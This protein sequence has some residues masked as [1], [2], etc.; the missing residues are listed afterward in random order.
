MRNIIIL[1]KSETIWLPTSGFSEN[2]MW[3]LIFL[4]SEVFYQ[5]ALI[6]VESLALLTFL[7][8]RRFVLGGINAPSALSF[9]SLW[10]LT[11]NSSKW[12]FFLPYSGRWKKVISEIF[13]KLARYHCKFDVKF[14]NFTLL[15]LL[16]T[17][18]LWYPFRPPSLQNLLCP[19]HW[20]CLF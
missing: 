16:Q 15:W 17:I 10:F 11:F 2:L 20:Y 9:A 18:W 14:K 6:P 19:D 1:F 13:S 8:G 7:W 12:M 5:P 4:L 3:S